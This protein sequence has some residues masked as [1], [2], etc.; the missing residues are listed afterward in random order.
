MSHTEPVTADDVRAFAARVCAANIT[1]SPHEQAEYERLRA[2]LF[3][4]AGTDPR[5]IDR[6]AAVTR[7]AKACLTPGR[8]GDAQT[9]R[10]LRIAIT[11]LVNYFA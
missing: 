7:A 3:A 4:A 1:R 8:V 5:G 11:A 6:I 9:L 2:K 10:H